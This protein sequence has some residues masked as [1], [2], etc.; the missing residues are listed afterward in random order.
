MLD[1]SRLQRLKVLRPQPVDLRPDRA[2]GELVVVRDILDRHDDVA[3]DLHDRAAGLIRHPIP[4]PPLM[5]QIPA[6]AHDHLFAELLGRDHAI[7]HCVDERVDAAADV[8]Q[9]DDDRIEISDHLLSRLARFA[10]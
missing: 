3:F 5:L 10:V 6:V 9:V 1:R 7:R 2:G 4:P 8:L